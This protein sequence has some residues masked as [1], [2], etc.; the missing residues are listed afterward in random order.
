MKSEEFD[1]MVY[2]AIAWNRATTIPAL[3]KYTGGDAAAVEASVQRLVSYLLIEPH[4]EEYRALSLEESI[5]RCHLRAGPGI[6]L[7]IEDGVIKIPDFARKGD[8]A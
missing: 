6:P 4:D 1:W 3:V 2:H 5:L 7:E 8:N